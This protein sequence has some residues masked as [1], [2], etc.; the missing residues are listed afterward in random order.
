MVSKDTCA[1]AGFLQR[2]GWDESSLIALLTCTDLTIIR[3]ATWT[4]AHIGTMRS[5]IPLA[6]IL[7]NDDAATADLAENALWSI[8]LRSAP[9]EAYKRLCAAIRLAE[10]DCCD[11]AHQEMDAILRDNPDY[12]EAYNQR[13]IVKF[14]KSDFAGAAADYQQAFNLN[15]VHFG[16]LA[17]LGHC[18]AA[19]GRYR[20][21]LNVYRRVLGIHP[22]MEGIRT[23][24]SQIQRMVGFSA[25]TGRL[26][27][28][29]AQS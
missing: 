4:L 24:I 15:P 20:D 14:L 1:L 27:A 12:C 9:P 13:A 17:G 5:S 11:Q 28:Y 19:L 3:A 25:Q 16:A 29:W 22:R 7:H 8:W 18:Y 6:T 23:A 10:Q 26:P 21:S 2:S